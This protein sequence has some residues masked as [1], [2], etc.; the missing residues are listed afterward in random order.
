[1]FPMR[2]VNIF[3]VF[4]A[5]AAVLLAVCGVVFFSIRILI[6]HFF[7]LNRY[8]WRRPMF[9]IACFVLFYSLVIVLLRPR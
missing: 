4:V 3:G 1:M 6:N 7:D 9:D 2:E 5:P 8:V